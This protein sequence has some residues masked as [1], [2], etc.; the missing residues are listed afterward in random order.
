MV[1]LGVFILSGKTK[2]EDASVFN[3][4]ESSTTAAGQKVYKLSYPGKDNPAYL[5]RN[6][7]AAKGARS[8]QIGSGKPVK[9]ILSCPSKSEGE[10]LVSTWEEA[11][12]YVK[13]AKDKGG[14]G[15]YMGYNEGSNSVEFVEDLKAH[16][17][18]KMWLLFRLENTTRGGGGGANGDGYRAPK[19]VKIKRPVRVPVHIVEESD[20]EP[21][22]GEW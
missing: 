8:L 19:D 10:A 2:P 7:K 14:S 4:V 11:P 17:S 20:S 6:D 5:A 13:I 21:E 1:K 9:F 22:F 15:G 12:C 16:G 18:G 3:V